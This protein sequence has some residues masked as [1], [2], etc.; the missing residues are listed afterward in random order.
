MED[1]A[2]AVFVKYLPLFQAI[3]IPNFIIII[4]LLFF[5]WQLCAVYFEV[6]ENFITTF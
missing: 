6:T 3:A 4:Y 2:L 5:L 1:K